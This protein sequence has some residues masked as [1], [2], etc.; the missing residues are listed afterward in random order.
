MKHT[1]FS[2]DIAK[3]VFEIAVSYEPGIVR[4]SHRV[5][6]AKFLE[7]FAKREKGTVVMEACSSC[8]F[9]GREVEKL[10]H[11]A[12]LLPPHAVR[13]YVQRNKTDRADAKG[14]LEAYRNKEIRPVPVKTVAQ[15]TVTAL[16]RMRSM[17]LEART[18]RL[19]TLRGLLREIGIFIPVGA[20]HVVP[21]VSELVEDADSD[22]PNALRAPLHEMCLEIRGLESR[23]RQAEREL[24]ALARQMPVVVR[25]RD[26]PGVG[27]L[28]ATALVAFVGDVQRFR[29]GRQFASYLGLTPREHSSG[30]IR[31]LGRISKRGDSYIRM[32]LTH[33]ARSVLWASKRVKA[34]D[35]LRAW[36]LEVQRRRGHN[37][38]AI[39]LANKLA[40][41]AWVV[42]KRDV[43]FVSQ[44]LAA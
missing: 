19:N 25:L 22:I 20:K 30:S 18:S 37:K 40:R 36:A 42:W 12:V 14:I 43:E 17:W 8:H 39:A 32:L 38:A 4:E 16:H 5:A 24:E 29:S 15:H 41:I 11:R 6:R 34:P 35:R 7:F 21:Q 44:P 10:G 27:L 3:N 33:G 2:V 1:T 13:P 31:R 23:M 9:W 28:T 26:I